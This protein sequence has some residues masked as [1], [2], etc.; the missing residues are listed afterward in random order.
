MAQEEDIQNWTGSR[1]LPRKIVATISAQNPD[2]AAAGGA[3]D[4]TF[5]FE[6]PNVG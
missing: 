1:D 3:L 6:V 5:L 2:A 4:A